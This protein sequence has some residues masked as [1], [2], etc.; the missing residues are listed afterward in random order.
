MLLF[1]LIKDHGLTY[2]QSRCVCLCV[3]VLYLP[4]TIDC[5]VTLSYI[6]FAHKI[7]RNTLRYWPNIYSPSAG[8]IS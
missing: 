4:S 2:R 6:C 7:V 3:S 1:N 5:L 8:K